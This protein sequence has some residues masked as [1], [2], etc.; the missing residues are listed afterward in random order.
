MSRRRL[1]PLTTIRAFE[2]A[3]RRLSIARASE[4]LNVTPAAISHQVRALEKWLGVR[5]FDRLNGNLRLTPAGITYYSGAAEGLDKLWYVTENL[6]VQDERSTIH[7]VAPVS[8]TTSWLVPRLHRFHDA[9]PNVEVRVS[10]TAPPVDYS[11]HIMDIGV[12]CG[13]EHIGDN[14]SLPWM[15][16]DIVAACS[17][18]LLEGSRGIRTPGDLAKHRLLHDDALMVLDRMDW[19]QWLDRFGIEGIDLTKTIRFSHATHAYQMAIAGQGV[20]LAKTAL[21]SE[22]IANGQLV[23]L[24][25]HSIPSE[26]CYQIIYPEALAQSPKV[27]DFR[28]WLVKEAGRLP[29]ANDDRTIVPLRARIAARDR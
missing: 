25:G 8:F 15:R 9:R 3:A 7:V 12:A 24:F 10:V 19:R 27:M 2:A 1:P 13:T 22:E 20:V 6:A 18:R 21:I 23:A 29:Y 28:D 11:R 4:E 14:E 26:R 17:P 16:Y 5:L